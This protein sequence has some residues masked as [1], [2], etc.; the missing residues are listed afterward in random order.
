MKDATATPGNTR[1]HKRHERDLTL[2]MMNAVD[3][4]AGG[5]N[6]TE[7]AGLLGLHR[8]TVT[9]WRCFDPVF[10]AALNQRRSEVWGRG[11]DRLRSMIPEALDALAAE[12]SGAGPGRLKAAIE[13]L[14]LAQLPPAS[15]GIGATDPEAVVRQIV[16]ER[17]DAAPNRMMQ[18]VESTLQ[19]LPP[20]DRHVE[21][22]WQELEQVA[23]SESESDS[24]A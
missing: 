21:E 19:G 5:R 8:T 11:L 22:V 14:R 20:W 1:Q 17:R 18:D 6:D 15:S 13:V 3:L 23:T 10:Q 9:K 7:V 2:A 24:D 16:K 4:L 12:L